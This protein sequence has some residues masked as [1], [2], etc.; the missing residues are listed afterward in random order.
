MSIFGGEICLYG[1]I[2][3]GMESGRRNW[4]RRRLIPLFVGGRNGG[5]GKLIP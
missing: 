4:R 5:K 2:G 1:G 3:G